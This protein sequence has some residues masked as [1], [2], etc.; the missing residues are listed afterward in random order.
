M[1][2]VNEVYT[3]NSVDENHSTV[4]KVE[5]VRT[6]ESNQVAHLVINI[7]NE[8]Y[9]KPEMDALLAGKL[10]V[11]DTDDWAQFLLIITN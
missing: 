7:Y 9:N 8:G 4:T 10:D 5:E 11:P 6:L 1:K 2:T 3:V